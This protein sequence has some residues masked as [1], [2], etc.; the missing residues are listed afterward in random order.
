MSEPGTNEGQVAQADTGDTSTTVA[1]PNGSEG[2][3]AG[4]APTTGNGQEQVTQ[5][6]S[7]FDP[8]S[9]ADKPELMAAYKQ[10]QGKFTKAMQGIRGDQQRLDLVRQFEADPVG[11]I[12]RLAP[13]YGVSLLEGQPPQQG[14]Q[15]FEPK[16]WDDVV[17][18]IRREV[19]AELAQQYEPMLNEVK[20]LKTQT[21]QQQLDSKYPDWATYEDEMIQNLQRHPSLAND[22][23]LLYRMSVPPE[24]MEAR[25]TEAA[26]KRLK[27]SSDSAT[28][29]A[30]TAT[31]QTSTR[32][33]GKMS[34][35]EAV[36]FARQQLK[37]QGIVRPTG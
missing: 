6:E 16:S 30:P 9:I 3:S 26:L 25:A 37:A 31:Q 29:S 32:P 7:F 21:V 22:T 5:G 8:K 34:F 15:K 12:R 19:T 18:H 36:Q 13:Q 33:K 27:G 4:P 35:D 17:S 28:V 11:T 10:M 14:E 20:N 2:Q 24:V 23:D 1:T